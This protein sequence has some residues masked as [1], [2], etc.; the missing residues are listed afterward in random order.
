MA[1]VA[2]SAAGR[3]FGAVPGTS[4]RGRAYREQRSE[5]DIT[6]PLQGCCDV[7]KHGRSPSFFQ[8]ET[9]FQSAALAVAGRD[10]S[11]VD[12]H[13]VL[14]DRKSE[15]RTAQFARAA[16]VDAVEALEEVRE[17]L[18]ADADSV[19]GE[20]ERALLGRVVQQT[21]VDVAS[22][23][24]GRGVVREVAED[25]GQQRGVAHDLDPLRD[26]DVHAQPLFGGFQRHFVG[27]LGDQVVQHDGLLPDQLARLVH[28]RDGRDVG[29]QAAQAFGLRDTLF[30]ELRTLAALHPGV[31]QQRFQIALNRRHGGFQLVVDV[32]RELFLDADLLLL[33]VQRQRMLAV[34][35][36][37]RALQAGV[38]TDDVVRNL[39][40][41][42]VREGG[43]VVDALA[44]FG[45]LCEF[46]QPRDVVPQPPRGEIPRDAHQQRDAQHEPEELAVGGE[47][48]AQRHG[49]GHG[50]ADDD[51]VAEHRR[52]EVV[53]MGALRVA[54]DGVS[55]SVS[56]CVGDFG[57]V[58]VV[59]C[60]ERV[61]RVVEEDE[62]GAVDDRHA[63]CLEGLVVRGDEGG[64]VGAFVQSVEHPQVEELQAGVEPLG[65]EVL[66][67]AVLEEHEAPHERPR[68]GQQQ[69]EEPPVV[70]ETT[71][72]IHSHIRAGLRCACRRVR[73]C[74]AG[75]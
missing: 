24:V 7:V 52:V 55:G 50:R 1:A 33:L 18:L 56:Q 41:F 6:K 19:V 27:H 70:G 36:G 60:G 66:L 3:G 16:L 57:P 62:S 38:E 49:V 4:G 32:V 5:T 58:E 17:V 46:V 30:E 26:V 48:L 54:A 75:G 2:G 67:A 45:A 14:D 21:D 64:G 71:P 39:A 63:Q 51:L 9:E 10:R 25:R 69:Q 23:G 11:A 40:Q 8:R 13:G 61:E 15:P 37:G 43:D 31:G 59:G 65:L 34:A 68:E 47:H 22:P 53:V 28:A 29:K 42:V 35:V 72:Q 12:H 73:S 44:A 74:G 20:E